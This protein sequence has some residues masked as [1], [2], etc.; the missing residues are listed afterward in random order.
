[1]HDS[2]KQEQ[3]YCT[4]TPHQVASLNEEGGR[5]DGRAS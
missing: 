1:M 3:E 5:H 2:V 4:D